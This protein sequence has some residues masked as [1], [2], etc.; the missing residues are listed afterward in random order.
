MA[1]H[2]QSDG[3]MEQVNQEIEANLSIYC[4]SYPED[5][6]DTIYIMEFTHIN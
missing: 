4:T 5:W 3:T 2:L 1:Y 6:L